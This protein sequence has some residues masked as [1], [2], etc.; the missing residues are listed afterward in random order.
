MSAQSRKPI[1]S[2]VPSFF[3]RAMLYKSARAC[4]LLA[5]RSARY[6]AKR[7]GIDARERQAYD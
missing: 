3:V 2:G 4:L 7:K 5:A 6:S 1:T